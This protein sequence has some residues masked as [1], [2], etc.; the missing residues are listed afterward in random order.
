MCDEET[1]ELL[2]RQ[3]GCQNEGSLRI[4]HR[5]RCGC[6]C[7]SHTPSVNCSLLA[8]TSGGIDPESQG[9]EVKPTIEPV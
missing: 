6:D 9:E 2:V 5:E 3:A 1:I 8:T 4:L 7:F